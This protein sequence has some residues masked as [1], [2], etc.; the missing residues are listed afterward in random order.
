MTR[1]KDNSVF[2]SNIFYLIVGILLFLLGSIVQ[3]RE[4]YSGLLITEYIIILI[5]NIIYLKSK[6]LSLKEIFRLNNINVKQALYVIAITI[7]SYPIAVFANLIMVSILS[8]FGEL[9]QSSA[10]IP[11][12]LP[13]YIISLFVIAISPGICEEI[14][15]RGTMMNAYEN[16]SKRKAIIYSA[17]LF[18]VFHLNVQNLLGPIVLGI[19]FGIV[20]YK[21]NSIYSSML[22]HAVNN[23]IA[24]TIGYFATKAGELMP[25]DNEM[26]LGPIEVPLLRLQMII[27]IMTI[28]AFALVSF[29]ILKKL[30]KG[31]PIGENGEVVSFKNTEEELNRNNPISNNI[32]P[33]HYFPIALFFV[34]FIYINIR[35]TYI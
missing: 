1:I 9:S 30:I 14:M 8:L 20:V 29:L 34:L 18:G 27:S 2:H 17:V 35:F 24:L 15:F 3:S 26:G 12:T 28:G 32:S 25:Q 19:V 13:L 31:L 21:T 5:P 23:G 4:I 7:F 11:D 22:G 16:L 6:D 33:L 10:P